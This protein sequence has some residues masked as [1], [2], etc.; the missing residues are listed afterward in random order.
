VKLL[1]TYYFSFYRK[2]SYVLD[3]SAALGLC[4]YGGGI[5]VGF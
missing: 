1:L 3:I 4:F 5:F 2:G